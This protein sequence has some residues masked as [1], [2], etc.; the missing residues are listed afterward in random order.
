MRG[1]RRSRGADA[2]ALVA[3]VDQDRAFELVMDVAEGKKE[4]VMLIAGGLYALHDNA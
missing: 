4:D 2:G 1:G 3:D